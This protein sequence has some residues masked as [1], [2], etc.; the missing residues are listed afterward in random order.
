MLHVTALSRRFGGLLALSDYALKLNRGEI[1]GIIGPNGAGKTTALNILS[2]F[3]PP[4]T[5]TIRFGDEDVTHMGA[6]AIARRGMARTFQNIRLFGRLSAIDNV[7]IGSQIRGRRSLSATLFATAQF[8]RSE[9]Q[10][11]EDALRWLDI[12]GLAPYASLPADHLA[13]GNQR[14]LEMARAMATQ[15][16]V[17]LLDEPAAGMNPAETD[18][19]MKQIRHLRDA[20][21]VA[22]ILVEHAM[23]LV[24]QVCDRI[25]V[26]NYGKLIAEGPPQAVRRDPAVIAAYLGTEDD[27]AAA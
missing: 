8:R 19:L 3:V 12:F 21:G 1:V 22:I 7:R 10:Y 23:R 4:S 11:T 18:T 2:G 25:Q 17:L 9:Q 5:G 27:H 26:L 6:D 13:Y 20:Y 14:R 15:P 16:T 24:M